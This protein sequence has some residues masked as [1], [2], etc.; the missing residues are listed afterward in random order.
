MV[1]SRIDYTELPELELAGLLA[2]RDPEAVRLITG[3]NNQ[4]LYRTAWSILKNRAEAEDAVQS[5][6]L[7]AFAAIEQFEGR[8]LLSTWLTR[9]VVNEAFGRVRAVRRRAAQLDASSIVDLDHYRETLMQGSATYDRPDGA[10]AREQVRLMLEAAVAKL[11]QEFR[12]V[13][14]LREIEG[15]SVEETAETL[16]L[17]PATVKTRLLR[18]RLRLREVLAPEVRA[19]L[20]GAFP[21]AGAD[22]AAITG[23]VIAALRGGT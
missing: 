4:R 20:E 19:T 10:L 15:M 7:N 14:V 9:I 12:T 1:L 21:F 2:A 23:R 18:A 3:R 17:V 5:A 13:F 11:P 16:D 22:C 6:Y 8:S